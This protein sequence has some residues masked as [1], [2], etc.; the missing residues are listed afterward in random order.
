MGL[1]S[2]M[3]DVLAKSLEF[4]RESAAIKT[5]PKN[6]FQK[7]LINLLQRLRDLLKV[8]SCYRSKNLVLREG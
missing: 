2:F 1:G 3:H 6:M 7:W 5:P 4:Q 8:K